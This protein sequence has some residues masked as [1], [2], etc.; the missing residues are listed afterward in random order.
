M[1]NTKIYKHSAHRERSENWQT[2]YIAAYKN[3]YKLSIAGE[4]YGKQEHFTTFFLCLFIA[5][6]P[7]SA[8]V[9][10]FPYLTLMPFQ[11]LPFL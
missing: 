2:L 4:Q 7:L 10:V 5:H 11:I 8:Q 9:L 3:N 1:E 6:K